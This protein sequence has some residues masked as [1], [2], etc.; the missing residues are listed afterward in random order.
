MLKNLSDDTVMNKLYIYNVQAS[1]IV[2]LK[3]PVKSKY[4]NRLFVSLVDHT[5]NHNY[6]GPRA[7][8]PISSYS[9]TV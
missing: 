1:I 4:I 9:D 5:Y 2:V 7:G 8:A 3:I 6:N